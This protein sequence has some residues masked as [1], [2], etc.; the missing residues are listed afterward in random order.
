MT[1]VASDALTLV[2]ASVELTGRLAVDRVSLSVRSGEVVGILGA[3]GAGKTTLL[4]ATLG[5]ARLSKGES[6]LAG[7]LVRSLTE[8]ERSRLA[9]YLPQSRHVVWNL[10][11]WRLAALGIPDAEPE[12]VKP[13][14]MAALALLGVADLGERGVFDMSGG[15]RARADAIGLALERAATVEQALSATTGKVN[16]LFEIVYISTEVYN[17]V[18]IAGAGHLRS[19]E[20]SGFG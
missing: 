15:E 16:E 18:V 1:S 5:L 13:T 4:R 6:R 11:A 3:N 8:R 12:R 19:H 17:E 14:V 20:A 10:P 2:G 9:A 7:R